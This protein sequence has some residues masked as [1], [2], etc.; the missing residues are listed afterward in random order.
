MKSNLRRVLS[1]F[2][3][4]AMLCTLLPLSAISVAAANVDLLVNGN[5]ETGNGNGWKLESG[6]SVTTDDVHGGSYALKTTNT[7][8]KYQTM[9]RQTIDVVAVCTPRTIGR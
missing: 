7:S 3:V 1:V 9:A 4:L 5:F 6:T 2:A 8:T